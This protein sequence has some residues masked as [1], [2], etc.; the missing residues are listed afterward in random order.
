MQLVLEEI[1]GLL[2]TSMAATAVKKYYVGKVDSPPLN[3]LPTICVYGISTSL[4]DDLGTQRDKYIYTIGIDIIMSGFETVN[5]AGVEADSILDAQKALVH[6]FEERSATGVPNAATVL[7]TLRRNISGSN[8]LFNNDASI[9]YD[10]EN[11][12]NDTQYVKGTLTCSLTTQLTSR[13]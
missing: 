3:Y 1:Q 10:F 11:M 6:L 12:V 4:A 9:N 7:G 2:A 8:F 5:T 13:S